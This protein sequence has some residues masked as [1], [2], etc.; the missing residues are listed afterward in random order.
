MTK[1]GNRYHNLESCSGLKRTVKLVK[2]SDVH[3]MR[4][5]SCLRIGRRRMELRNICTGVFSSV[6]RLERS[7][8]AGNPSF[9]HCAFRRRGTFIQPVGTETGG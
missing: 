6:R 1:S 5:C 2:Q 3:G 8:E 9:P 4:A 7:E